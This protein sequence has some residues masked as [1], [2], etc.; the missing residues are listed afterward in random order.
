MS[1]KL[2]WLDEP[3]DRNQPDPRLWSGSIS[4]KPEALKNRLKT[5]PLKDYLKVVEDYYYP[6]T[7]KIH[8]RCIDGRK[9]RHT[10]EVK[11]RDELLE[12]K[13]G[14]QAPGGSPV[15]ALTHRIAEWDMRPEGN[16]VEDVADTIRLHAK[17]GLPSSVGGHDDDHAE[18][19]NTGCGAI[20]RMPEILERIADP[21]SQD[22]I[23]DYTKAIVG[24][25]FSDDEFNT[26]LQHYRELETPK[27]KRSYLLQS[28]KGEYQYKKSTLEALRGHNPSSIETMSGKHNEI[29]VVIN[30]VKGVTFHRDLFC[31]D[32][33]NEAQ[34]FNYDF[35]LSEELANYIYPTKPK[36]GLRFL[37]SRAIY[38]VG[39]CM[40]LTDGSL[41]VGIRQ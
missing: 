20:D 38:A 32:S 40:V 3:L 10:A 12:E 25:S 31:W 34:I 16:I 36:A 2:T 17:L 41:A 7:P 4:A 5:K 22:I 13:L 39:T 18:F 26:V 8:T 19:P 6:I 21:K 9:S 33:N 37:I 30:K 15:V 24:E 28:P 35:W 1:R 11:T 27:A 23:Y 14:P 29:A